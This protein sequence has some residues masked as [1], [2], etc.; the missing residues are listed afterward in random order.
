VDDSILW[1]VPPDASGGGLTRE[2]D[3][4]GAS[5]NQSTRTTKMIKHEMQ[6]KIPEK[7]PRSAVIGGKTALFFAFLVAMPGADWAVFL[8]RVLSVRSELASIAGADLPRATQ[9]DP[10]PADKLAQAKLPKLPAAYQESGQLRV[11]ESWWSARDG[12]SRHLAPRPARGRPAR[13]LQS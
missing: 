4:R 6:D 13:L 9:R 2:P 10:Q 12:A 3:L 1:N 8:K 11:P 7:A 5:W